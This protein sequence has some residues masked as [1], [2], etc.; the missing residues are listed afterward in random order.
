M[1]GIHRKNLGQL[2]TVCGHWDARC[3]HTSSKQLYLPGRL[4]RH[5]LVEQSERLARAR[6][7]CGPHRARAHVISRLMTFLAA[8]EVIVWPLRSNYGWRT[9]IVY[10]SR[11]PTLMS[12]YFIVDSSSSRCLYLYDTV[13]PIRH[14]SYIVSRLNAKRPPIVSSTC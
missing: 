10:E 2:L 5:G 7:A 4:T 11:P 14:A 1:C 9:R 3:W 12:K 6:G 8:H 13:L